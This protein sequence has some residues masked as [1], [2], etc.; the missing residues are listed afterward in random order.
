MSADESR[1]E[2]AAPDQNADQGE[3]NEVVEP[4]EPPIVFA[5]QPWTEARYTNWAIET[6]APLIEEEEQVLDLHTT[7]VIKGR[8]EGT[9]YLVDSGSHGQAFMKTTS[10][11]VEFTW[12]PVS[13]NP[14]SSNAMTRLCRHVSLNQH[15]DARI[16]YRY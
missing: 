1:R 8:F 9:M 3:E 11:P 12:G 4:P 16:G 6:Y 15:L 14:T 13:W 2:D 10:R 7:T 5:V